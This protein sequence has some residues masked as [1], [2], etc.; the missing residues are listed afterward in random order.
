MRRPAV[1]K[2]N[3]FGLYVLKWKDLRDLAEGMHV[4][5][6]FSSTGACIYE[7]LSFFTGACASYK[8]G[9]KRKKEILESTS[10]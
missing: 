2:K 9:G 8:A 4:C 1:I 10:N 5:G 6:L 7:M 3:G